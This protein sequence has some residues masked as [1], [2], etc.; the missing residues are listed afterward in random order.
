MGKIYKAFNYFF[1][2]LYFIDSCLTNYLKMQEKS[3]ALTYPVAEE[4]GI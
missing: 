4:M 1:F 3:I 2:S